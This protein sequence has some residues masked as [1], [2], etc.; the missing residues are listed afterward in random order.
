M[1]I[2]LSSLKPYNLDGQD[3]LDS[4]GKVKTNSEATFLKG[5]LITKISKM[6]NRMEIN[7]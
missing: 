1:A 6:R 5:F 3:M 2:K 4:A 7:L